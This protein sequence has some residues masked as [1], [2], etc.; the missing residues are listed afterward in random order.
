MNM[1]KITFAFLASLLLCF[2][3]APLLSAAEAVGMIERL[4]GPASRTDTAGE[5]VVST[6]SMILV[7][8]I[9]KTGNGSR[10]IVRFQDQSTLTLG[11][12]AEV[13]VDE[14]IYTPAGAEPES[15]SQ[16]L[17]FVH[18]VFGYVSGKVGKAIPRNVALATPVATIGIR[19]TEVIFGELTVGMPPGVPHYG[20]QIYD[21]AVAITSTQGTVILDEPGE[22]TFLPIGREAAPTPVRQWTDEEAQE[23][24]DA[25]RF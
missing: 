4:K 25:L 23:A 16:S 1:R 2:A 6:G 11:E 15:G 12:N 21:G 10:M 20:F 24:L 8:D 14:M 18:G 17:K 7:G 22:G 13:L 9:L 19:G 3:Y 5:T